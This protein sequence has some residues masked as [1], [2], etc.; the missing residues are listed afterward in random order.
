M[1]ASCVRLLVVHDK[2]AFSQKIYKI[3]TNITFLQK[4]CSFT[5]TRSLN[6]AW[7]MFI[8]VL[9]NNRFLFQ[10]R[11]QVVELLWCFCVSPHKQKS[12]W[13]MVLMEATNWTS[14]VVC[15]IPCPSPGNKWESRPS[16]TQ[17]PWRHW[18]ANCTCHVEK[19]TAFLFYRLWHWTIAALQ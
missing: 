3:V 2:L 14:M 4:T 10:P 11:S 6:L 1:A 19:L 17:Q 18:V 9:L 5:N 16:L 13:Q 12:K 15:S 7:L 8:S